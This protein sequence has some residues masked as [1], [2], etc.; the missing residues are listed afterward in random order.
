MK[1]L[2][3]VAVLFMAGFVGT[4]GATEL[5]DAI[6]HAQFEQWLE[7]A[8][9]ARRAAETTEVKMLDGKVQIIYTTGKYSEVQMLSK[10][11]AVDLYFQLKGV[12]EK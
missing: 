10:E 3:L 6:A 4:A 2:F 9:P 1:P 7:K 12:I 8:K 11:K 5:E